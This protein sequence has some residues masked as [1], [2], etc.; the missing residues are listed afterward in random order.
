MGL[1]DFIKSWLIPE[2]DY[3]EEEEK[4]IT[5]EYDEEE[6]YASEEN[7]VEISSSHYENLDHDT[8]FIYHA[9]RFEDVRFLKPVM[10]ENV[11]IVADLA[12]IPDRDERRRFLDFAWGMAR[13]GGGRM[14]VLDTKNMTIAVILPSNSWKFVEE[15]SP[16][17][18]DLEDEEGEE[19]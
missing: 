14:K 12:E 15:N 13:A 3:D 7:S 19:D 11:T 2:E 1:L 9:L 10:K 17:Y 6:E 5:E 18:S 16:T 8:V 4:G